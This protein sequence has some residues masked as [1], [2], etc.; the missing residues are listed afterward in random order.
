MMSSI[1]GFGREKIVERKF[2][3]DENQFSHNSR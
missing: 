3:R 2:G 1:L